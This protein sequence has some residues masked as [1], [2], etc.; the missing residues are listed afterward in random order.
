MS[1]GGVNDRARSSEQWLERSK[2][3]VTD[4]LLRP[5]EIPSFQ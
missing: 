2:G 3:R 4:R 5:M 1:P